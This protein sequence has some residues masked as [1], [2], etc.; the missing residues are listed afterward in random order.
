M[1][2]VSSLRF[3]KPTLYRSLHQS[4]RSL[5]EEEKRAPLEEA[6]YNQ[7]QQMEDIREESVATPDVVD[8]TQ[9]T[10]VPSE[11]N[12]PQGQSGSITEQASNMASSIAGATRSAT[13]TISEAAQRAN[14]F[15]NTRGPR[16]APTAEVVPNRI[17]YIGNLFFE[18][19]SPQLELEFGRFG[20]IVN[21]RIVTDE[22]GLSRGFAYVEFSTQDA[23]DQAVQELNQTTFQGRRMSV[24]YHNRPER[25]KRTH[26]NRAAN[27]ISKTLYI[28]NMSYQMSDRDLNGMFQ[29]FTH[30]RA[31]C[32]D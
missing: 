20:E 28:G 21:S 29:V 2:R 22:R 7:E 12:A 31:A 3:Q 30:C 23:A 14:P 13:S 32:K 10:H 15:Q 9:Q 16:A 8:V 11:E 17:L 4:W 25:A 26:I 18:V 27:P 1:C 19:T 5:A 24:Q 6:E